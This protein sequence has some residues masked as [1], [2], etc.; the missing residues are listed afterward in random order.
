M[1]LGDLDIGLLASIRSDQSV[2]L[3]WLDAVQLLTG[4]LDLF[5]VRLRVHYEDQGVVVFDG[6]DG[7]F[8][9]DWMT[10]NGVFVVG[11]ELLVRHSLDLVSYCGRVSL[12]SVESDLCP[13]LLLLDSL[14]SYFFVVVEEMYPS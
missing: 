1:L 9:R 14:S 3:N 8:A 13:Y 12:G 5:L 11:G 7:T 10:D 2:D 6:A 4:L